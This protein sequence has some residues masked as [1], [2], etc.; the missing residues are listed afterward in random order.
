MNR[1]AVCRHIEALG[2]V[3]IE[4]PLAAARFGQR[5]VEGLDRVNGAPPWPEP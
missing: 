3:G 5:P 2:D 4:D 1:S